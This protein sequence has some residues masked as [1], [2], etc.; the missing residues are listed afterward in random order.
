MVKI[1]KIQYAFLIGLLLLLGGCAAERYRQEGLA[2]LKEGRLEEGISQLSKAQKMEPG[3]ASLKKDFLL[4]RDAITLKLMSE[5]N[6][7]RNSGN[8]EAALGTLNRLLIIDPKHQS[9]R[10]VAYDIQIERKQISR[11][12]EATL[13]IKKGDFNLSNEIISFVISIGNIDF[14]FQLSYSRLIINKLKLFL[15]FKFS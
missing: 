8:W 13:L 10:Q 7:D 2:M 3:N 15:I 5:A 1:K 6:H 14:I 11:L 4:E 12:D 9:A